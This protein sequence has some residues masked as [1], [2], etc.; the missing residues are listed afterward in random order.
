MP[1]LISH[2]EIIKLLSQGDTMVNLKGKVAVVT[3]ASRGV[4]KGIALG[5]GE[6]GAT[7]Y[8][9]G[10]TIKDKTDAEQLGGTIFE[11]AQAVNA[12]GGKGVAIQCDHREDSQ[13]E[14]AFKHV[15]KKSKQC[16]GW[17]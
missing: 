5:L 17:L 14:E 12:I 6:A 3:G 2:S 9:T 13:V 11:T 16:L 15:A 1:V 7:V 8:V 4:G 10:R